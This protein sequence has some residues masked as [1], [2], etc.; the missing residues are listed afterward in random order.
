MTPKQVAEALRRGQ[1]NDVIAE[2][3]PKPDV[4]PELEWLRGASPAEVLAALKSGKLDHVIDGSFAAESV[5]S[6]LRKA[7]EA[8]GL[9]A[10]D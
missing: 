1:F 10:G 6:K 2:G 5:S 3:N 8:E 9:V 4:E 7:H